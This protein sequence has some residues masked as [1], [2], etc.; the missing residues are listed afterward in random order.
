MSTNPKT[1]G[2]INALIAS[3]NGAPARP[4]TLSSLLHGS[5]G[6]NSGLGALSSY[7][8]PQPRLR[9]VLEQVFARSEHDR[10]VEKLSSHLVSNL[11]SNI[12][13]DLPGHVKPDRIVWTA[14]QRGH[15]PDAI[16][17][18]LAKQCV[19]EVETA[20]SLG[21]DHTYEQCRLFSAYVQG[22]FAEFALVV[23]IGSAF[24]ARSQLSRWGLI[25]TV[26]EI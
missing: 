12:K 2:L 21:D 22:R 23:P 7:H 18:Y 13:V 8:A 5:L 3:R 20:D 24:D 1:L 16:A 19:F 4:L 17:Y 26:H 6:M 9:G 15:E 11:F 25:A 14:T 10:L